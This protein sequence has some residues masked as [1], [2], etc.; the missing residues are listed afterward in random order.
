MMKNKMD[1]IRETFTI[2]NV[3]FPGHGVNEPESDVVKYVKDSMRRDMGITL[4]NFIETH[5][6]P[7]VVML[8][9]VEMDD[10]DYKGRK[11]TLTVRV[12]EMRDALS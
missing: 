4:L 5:D 3:A 7:V 11:L 12:E 9:W 2:I 1:K 6:K 8:N 10:E